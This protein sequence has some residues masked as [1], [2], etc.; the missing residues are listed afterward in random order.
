MKRNK[1][2]GGVFAFVLF[3]FN[4]GFAL[5]GGQEKEIILG[6]YLKFSSQSLREDFRYFVHLPPGY[7]SNKQ[8]YPVIYVMNGQ[9]T[10]TMANAVSTVDSLSFELIPEMILIGLCNTGRAAN[11]FPVRPDGKPG[12]ADSFLEF[13][14]DEFV[15]FIDAQYRTADYQILMGQSNTGFFTVF[16]LLTKPNAF[17]AYIA[18]SPSLGWGLEFIKIK[19]EQTFSKYDRL[20]SFLYMTY[21]EKDYTDLVVEPILGFEEFLK[22]KAPSGLRWQI[23][24]L[25]KDGHVPIPSLNNGLLALFH[26]YYLSDEQRKNGLVWVD[27]HYQKL[28][29]RYGFQLSAS[30]E[31][32]FNMSYV[33]KQNKDYMGAISLF[34]ELLERYPQSVKGYYFLGDTYRE[35]GE[36]QKAINCYERALEINP[37]FSAAKKRMEGLKKHRF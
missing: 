15:P 6:K 30:E 19:A 31:V 5:Y 11:I 12:E 3:L 22:N 34:L 21:G 8:T 37:D 35:Q 23:D 4:F 36:I 1:Y 33:L 24:Y 16:A 27:K 18:A 29:Q 2:Y 26:D 14:T 17:H 32:L 13:L 10:T 9:M 28:S 7:G 20:Q 25:E